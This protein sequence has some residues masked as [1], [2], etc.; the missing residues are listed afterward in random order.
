MNVPFE[1]YHGTGNDFLIIDAGMTTLLR[2]AMYGSYHAIRNLESDADS[3]KQIPQTVTGPICE[4]SDVFCTDRRL[5]KSEHGDV[6]AIGNAGAYGYEMAN[7]Y[8]SR[9]R[10]ASVVL[11]GSQYR[12]S[13]RRETLADITR[14]EREIPDDAYER[15]IERESA[16]AVEINGE[17]VR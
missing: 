6:L 3:R 5:P 13:R 2:P 7:Q 12:V 17:H 11:D 14:T 1:K 16:K 8:N 4:S 9:P 10:P 15:P